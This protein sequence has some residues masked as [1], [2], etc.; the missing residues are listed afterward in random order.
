VDVDVLSVLPNNAVGT[1]YTASGVI[2]MQGHEARRREVYKKAYDAYIAP[3]QGIG[4]RVR[5]CGKICRP[6]AKQLLLDYLEHNQIAGIAAYNAWVLQQ[7]TQLGQEAINNWFKVNGLRHHLTS[8][9]SIP[10]PPPLQEIP[11]PRKD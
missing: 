3:V 10:D 1:V 2:D 9:Y 8:T 6:D 7:Q 11:C 4:S 5:R